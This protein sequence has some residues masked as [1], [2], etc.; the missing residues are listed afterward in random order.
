LIGKGMDA[1]T[2]ATSDAQKLATEMETRMLKETGA[3]ISSRL[4]ISL[5]NNESP[6][7]FFAQFD[8]G[9]RSRFTLLIDP[10][11]RI[12][13][14]SF[15]INGGEKVLLFAYAPYA[16]ENDM[17]IATYSEDDFSK[18]RVNYSDQFDLVSPSHYKMEIDLREARRMLHTKM[19]IDFESLA[20]NLRTIPM[21]LN[22]GLTEFDNIRLKESMRIKSAQFS[23]Q[24]LPYIQEDW[25][26][27]F[28]LIL[29]KPAQKGEKFSI[30]LSIEGDF[31]DNQTKILNGYYPQSNESWYPRHGYLKRSTFDLTFR[32]RNGDNV[33]SIGK[34]MR[35][36]EEWIKVT[37]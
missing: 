34:L 10:Q 36:N 9:T 15:G 28:T 37:G 2:A 6:G 5:S 19:R 17:W 33:A 29:P 11:A 32:H 13:G 20:D 23:G 21:L 27:G 12:P 3:N 30:D 16:Y 18:N 31:I 26:S 22:D 4:L 35:E 14:S 25:E 24:N 1:S 8:K 7:I